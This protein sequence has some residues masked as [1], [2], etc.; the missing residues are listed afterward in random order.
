VWIAAALVAAVIAV[1][2]E[3]R[4][5]VVTDWNVI[6]LQA[7]AAAGLNAVRRTRVLA[8][9]HAAVHDAV[10]AIDRRAQPYAF[11][12]QAAATA[13]RRRRAGSTAHADAA[14]KRWFQRGRPVR[15]RE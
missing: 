4:A 10:N 14:A 5:D 12:M 8:M 13:S 15:A 7:H 2:S 6:A 1:P 9:V 11:D 3:G